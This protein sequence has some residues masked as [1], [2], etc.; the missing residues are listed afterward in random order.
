MDA[1]ELGTILT[2]LGKN[3]KPE[4]LWEMINKVDRDCSGAIEWK[5]FIMLMVEVTESERREKKERMDEEHMT[6]MKMIQDMEDQDL[7]RLIDK[8]NEGK[9]VRQIER[10]ERERK[11]SEKI[12]VNIIAEEKLATQRKARSGWY[13]MKLTPKSKEKVLT[14]AEAEA[15]KKR[16][17]HEMCVERYMDADC[18]DRL[19]KI[20][21]LQCLGR[22][23][24]AKAKL[25]HKKR[26]RDAVERMQGGLRGKG[27]RNHF[28]RESMKQ[29]EI[30]D[31]ITERAVIQIQAN[32]RGILQRKRTTAIKERVE[33]NRSLLA[34][35]HTPFV[36]LKSVM[37][38]DMVQSLRFPASALEGF[39]KDKGV[40]TD[41]SVI[42]NNQTH[43]E[44]AM[45]A[46]N[47]NAI[48]KDL[49]LMLVGVPR[50][51]HRTHDSERQKNDFT[52]EDLS[53]LAEISEAMNAG[54]KTCAYF[55]ALRTVMEQT[56]LL[57][58]RRVHAGAGWG[59][60]VEDE[61]TM[62]WYCGTD[63]ARGR[64]AWPCPPCFV[65]PCDTMP[66]LIMTTLGASLI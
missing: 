35:L 5:E 62:I 7:D 51:H 49:S 38:T 64:S 46:L 17:F 15:E 41:P 37:S 61:N 14:P 47:E 31:E 60:M 42:Y 54:L 24:Y 27:V 2:A 53:F 1:D 11:M 34:A 39:D 50:G 45:C 55:E 32:F 8:V 16:L 20:L 18:P 26:E 22:V 3:P 56:A 25:L 10:A 9:K 28:R 29:K 40:S 13:K 4:E 30:E 6:Q 36:Q 63:S 66:R 12:R 23:K 57:I 43:R 44:L 65:Q 48:A 58:S 59:L 21:T 33:Y 19:T 52:A